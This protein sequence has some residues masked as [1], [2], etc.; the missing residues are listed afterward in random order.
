[1]TQENET[2]NIISDDG[3]DWIDKLRYSR[4]FVAKLILSDNAVKEYYAAITARLLSYQKVRS[5][6]G[7]NGVSFLQ[8]ENRLQR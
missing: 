1:M 2:H 7:W 6:T 3:N 4:S 8:A 5:K